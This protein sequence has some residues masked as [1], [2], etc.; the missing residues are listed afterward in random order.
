MKSCKVFGINCIHFYGIHPSEAVHLLQESRIIVLRYSSIRH[1]D[2]V[3]FL[4]LVISG[5]ERA[6]SVTSWPGIGVGSGT[7]S[8]VSDLF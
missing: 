8:P 3:S 6:E 5:V 1:P 7:V 4:I 2:N